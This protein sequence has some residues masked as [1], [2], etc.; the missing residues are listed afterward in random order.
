LRQ[1]FGVTTDDEV[2]ERL[3]IDLRRVM[4]AYIGP[5][6]KTGYT[7]VYAPGQDIFGVRRKAVSH[8]YGEYYEMEYS[9]LAAAVG[10]ADVDAYPWPRAQW[11]DWKGLLSQ[12][13]QANRKEEYYVSVFGGSVFEN[14]FPMRGFE[15]FLLDLGE[16]PELADR[17]MHKVADFDCEFIERALE[18]GQGRIDMVRLSD[19][20]GHQSGMLVSP[21]MWREMFRPHLERLIKTAK[22]FGVKVFYH[23]DGFIDPIIP[24]LVALGVDLLNPLQ[25][26]AM[27]ITPA[28]LKARYGDRLCFD[29]GLDAQHTLPYGTP[30]QVRA[31]T[32]MLI[33]TLGAGGGYILG[34]CHNMQPDVPLGNILAL[35]ETGLT[36]RA[37]SEWER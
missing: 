7:T 29:G 32:R 22:R 5:D 25:F 31:E 6:D 19:D 30:A 14:S 35:Y 24:D 3:G 9:P 15:Q 20:V 21:K 37:S 17:I 11:F 34:S 27:R 8:A 28:E 16:W 36:Y 4:P 18:A 33:D 12:V 1:H 13:E 26:S 23:S 2:L 10:L